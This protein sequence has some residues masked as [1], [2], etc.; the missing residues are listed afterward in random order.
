M[1]GLNREADRRAAMGLIER[2]RMRRSLLP[3]AAR[4]TPLRV[5]AR[6]H[7]ATTQRGVN[8]RIPAE[9]NLQG[10]PGDRHPVVIS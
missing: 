1:A 3:G 10:A 4:L 9:S 2:G 5:E 8:T 7:H 6:S